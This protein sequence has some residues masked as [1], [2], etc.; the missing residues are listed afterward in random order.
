MTE[1]LVGKSAQILEAIVAGGRSAPSSLFQSNCLT[2]VAFS[3]RVEKK[4]KTVG[5]H[6]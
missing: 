4:E 2:R 5:W 6:E 3:F 1:V